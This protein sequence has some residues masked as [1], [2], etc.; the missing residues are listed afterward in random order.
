ME[1]KIKTY[2]D[3]FMSVLPPDSPYPARS[4]VAEAWGDSPEMADELGDLIF[5]GIKTAT[6][7]ALWEWETE[8][9]PIPRQGQLTV[10]LDGKGNPLCIAET[11]EVTIRQYNEVDDEFAQAE[12]EGDFSLAYWREAHRNFFSRTL[13]KIGREFSEDMPLVC[14]RFTVIYK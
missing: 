10:V 14:E 2:L 4:F 3:K 9:K 5:R 6:C 11:T 8:G 12:G 1:E 7:S 13:L